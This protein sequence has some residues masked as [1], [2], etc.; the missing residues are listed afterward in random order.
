MNNNGNQNGG[1][2]SSV[3]F[4]GAIANNNGNQNGD[5]AS[6]SSGPVDHL[7]T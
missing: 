3:N 5:I 7:K 6:S 2:A 4:Q 1:I